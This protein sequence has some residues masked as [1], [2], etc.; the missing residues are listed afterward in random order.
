MQI[1]NTQQI[2]DWDQYTISHE[3]VSSIDLMERAAKACFDWL[4]ANGY[5]NRQFSIYCG[6]GNNG[7]DG[8]AIA[9]MLAITGHEVAVY[10]LEFGHK[11]TD[12]FQHNLALLHETS[13]D[14]VFISTESTVNPVPEKHIIIDALLGSGLNRALEGLTATLV[15]HI[16][17]SG[18]EVISIDIPTGMFTDREPVNNVV[19]RASHTLTFQSHKLA[20]LLGDTQLYTGQ[21]HIL[22]IGLH[23]GY[24]ENT[25]AD[26][27]LIDETLIRPMIRRRPKFSH[28]GNYGSGALIAGSKGMMGAAVLAAR[29]FMRSG[30]GKL[31]CHLPDAGYGV[32][33][34]AVPEAMC[35]VEG[36]DNISTMGNLSKYDAL[37]IGPGIGQYDHFPQ[38]LSDIFKRFRKPMVIDADALNVMARNPRLMSHLPPLSILTPHPGE[39]ARLFGSFESDHARIQAAMDK[40]KEYNV[41]IVLK[42]AHT[43]IATPGGK[44]YFN[45]TGNP[46][47]ATAGAGDV[48]TGLIAGLLC[49]GYPADHAAILGVY[50][51]GFSGDLAAAANSQQSLM[52]SDIVNFLGQAFRYHS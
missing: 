17:N 44:G 2:H 40:A 37:G 7:G 20:F 41:L 47:M 48:L 18:R 19:I 35:L 10:I 29:A 36:G 42:G 24:V 22:D 30:A 43:L 49:Q 4:M 21:L 45:N 46:G 34:G 14:I 9:R 6:K 1:F 23:Q 5:R 50:L 25:P 28:K 31:T 27:H 38:L 39:F 26:F 52:A 8:L 32:M 3:P 15:H 51:H 33:Q 12:D 11:G 16:N 13:A